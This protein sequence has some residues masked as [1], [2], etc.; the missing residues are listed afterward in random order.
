MPSTTINS[1]S[2][3]ALLPIVLS[4]TKPSKIPQKLNSIGDHLKKKRLERQLTQLQLARLI[5]VE[6]TSI[7]NWENNRS[8]PKI[9]LLP[10]IIEFLGYVPFK[11]PKETVGDKI[12]GYRKE[13][14]LSQRKLAKLWSVN[15][16]TIRNWDKE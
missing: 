9:Y 12:T 14:G 1:H 16:T 4:C 7:Y 5:G 6:E 8:K 15:Q 10:K 2:C 11:L 3:V 13:H